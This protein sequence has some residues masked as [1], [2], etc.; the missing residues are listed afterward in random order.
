MCNVNIIFISIVHLYFRKDYVCH[1]SSFKKVDKDKNLKKSKNMSCPAK[2]SIKVKKTTTD[3]V[4]KDKYVKVR[5]IIHVD[6]NI[7]AQFNMYNSILL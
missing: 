6:Y 2:I 5:I 7:I 4:K 1:H 3:T